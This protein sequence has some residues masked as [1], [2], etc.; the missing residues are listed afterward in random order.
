LDGEQP[1]KFKMDFYRSG[2]QGVHASTRQGQF[3]SQFTH[4]LA[5]LEHDVKSDFPKFCVSSAP[6]LW[7]NGCP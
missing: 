6:V 2:V 1:E 7:L 5:H 3:R 4:T